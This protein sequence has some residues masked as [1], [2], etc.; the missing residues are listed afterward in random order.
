MKPQGIT[1]VM[2]HSI[3]QPWVLSWL[4]LTFMMYLHIVNG[5]VDMQA[6]KT[7]SSKFLCWKCFC[8]I[9]ILRK[10]N[11]IILCVCMCTHMSIHPFVCRATSSFT[12]N[13]CHPLTM[14]DQNLSW[15]KWHTGYEV[16]RHKLVVN[17]IK[18]Y[19]IWMFILLLHEIY[20]DNCLMIF[21]DIW[22]WYIL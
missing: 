16:G 5:D 11:Y 14:R 20:F 6:V 7:L 18:N 4:V 17:F 22:A 1:T 8:L 3:Y 15:Y 21:S 10:N 2:Q 13:L 12:V 9:C 19:L